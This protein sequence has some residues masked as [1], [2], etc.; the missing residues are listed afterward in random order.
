MKAIVYVDGLAQPRN[1]GVGTYGF[2]V[3]SDGKKVS[4]GHG[5]AGENVTS[6][7]AEYTALVIALKELK[8]LG[9]DEVVVRSDS[10]LLVGQMSGEWKVKGGAY[11]ERLK[12]AR[13]LASGFRALR[14]EWVPRERNEEADMLSRVAYE[15]YRKGRRQ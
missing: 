4:E 12:E 5:V 7:Y 13:E 6:N 2:V 14:F 11:L 3:Y 8:R 10:K 1:P 9:F 15:A